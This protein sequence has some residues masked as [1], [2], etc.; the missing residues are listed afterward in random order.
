[1]PRISRFILLLLGT[2]LFPLSGCSQ[3]GGDSGGQ[4]VR[5]TDISA[6][7]DAPISYN[8]DIRPILSD[9]CFACHGPD[10]VAREA[11][12]R[13]DVFD[14][15]PDGQYFGANLA[16]EPGE[17]DASDLI[18]RIHSKKSR[19]VMPPPRFKV[20]LTED[21][22][23]LLEQWIE[24]GAAYEPHWAFVALPE[25][26]DPPKINAVD[27]PRDR[28]DHFVLARLEAEG[29]APSPE[30]SRERWLRRVT[31]DLTGLPPTPGEI[32][33]FLID[34]DPDANEKV[35]D[36][37][38]ASPHFG[39]RMAVPWLDMARY[40][41]TYGFTV[42]GFRAAWP[43]RD[44]VVRAFNDNLPYNKFLTWQLAG[45]LLPGAT[46]DQRLATA[47][48]RLH[49][50]NAEGGAIPEEWRNEGVAD[51][52]HTFGTAFMGLTLECARCHD[53]RY[54]PIGQDEYYELFAFFNSI[55]ESGT[56]EYR[57]PDI[58]P[59]PSMLLPTDQQQA[60][61][62]RLRQAVQDAAQ[63]GPCTH[64]PP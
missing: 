18:H 25:Q 26:I 5:A 30:A 43:W 64:Q 39:E 57:R 49:R 34:Q 40:A 16:I 1:M 3:G 15:D 35:V 8:R 19:I 61:L 42:D 24:Q 58:V 37:L 45:D 22:K 51:R 41:D 52:L 11:D 21:E 14:D 12:L 9:K 28:L 29:L 17:S 47:F 4:I 32:D 7:Q 33:A 50:M 53:H 56:T 36:R 62:D 44:W 23:A 55:D 54:D 20:T 60:E 10:S 13:L 46:R 27:W 31:Y 48:N 2:G 63:S 59:P 6:D 38:L